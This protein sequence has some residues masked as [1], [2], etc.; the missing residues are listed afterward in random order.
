MCGLAGLVTFGSVQSEDI[1][2]VEAMTETLR[3]RGPDDSGIWSSSNVVLGHRRLS[4]IDLDGGHQP[5]Q[6]RSGN[7]I[8]LYED[9]GVDC[10]HRL[11]GMF[12]F[13]LW[14]GNQ[15]KL[16]LG[17]DRAGIKPLYYRRHADGVTF[18][19]EIKALLQDPRYS[20]RLNAD[21]L[22]EFVQFRNITGTE[23][24][25]EGIEEIPPGHVAVIDPRDG[26]FR[27]SRWWK[28]NQAEGERASRDDLTEM[29]TSAVRYHMIADVEV[30]TY[31]S[32]GVDSSLVSYFASHELDRQLHTF[33]VGFE[34]AQFDE[35]RYSNI[36]ARTIGSNHHKI[37]VDSA[38]YADDLER[39]IWHLDEPLHHAHT[40]QLMALSK[41]A[42]KYV[43]VVLTG[44][45]ADEIFA[46]YP[47]Y[48]IPFLAPWVSWIPSGVRR[49]LRGAADDAGLRRVTKL[50]DAAS[51]L[52]SS[53]VN[54]AR[55]VDEWTLRELG[56]TGS[57][58]LD[59][60]YGIYRDLAGPSVLETVLAYDRATYMQS[61]LQRLDRTTMAHSLEA[62]VPYL[63]YR[64][65]E[66]SQRLH[67]S[68]KLAVGR[69]NKILLK[70][71]ARSV[72][73]HEIIDRRKMG[74]DVP[75]HEWLR[76]RKGLGARLDLLTDE[77][78]AGRGLYD[79]RYVHRLVDEH[80]TG[81]ANHVEVLWPILNLELW[82][83]IMIEGA[84]GVS[85]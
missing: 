1:G 61:L 70:D 6:S 77:T 2:L 25:F 17:R 67:P 22:W 35:S 66:W 79:V 65:V 16:L 45:G 37:S 74:F 30:G 76:D 85:R 31:N 59:T 3:H 46:G 8:H 50:I 49:A 51:D 75:L 43:K 78:F 27:L 28:D 62:R 18:A 60:R 19:S 12:A 4:I 11:N 13:A 48:Q 21:A 10:L 34:E 42:R 23:T 63:D 39:A 68:E 44:E 24:M 47:R 56:G 64:L 55:F 20:R 29:L 26:S 71:L 36:V 33:S 15:N 52:P 14:D 82:Q 83:R 57:V 69:G 72:F 73:P 40:V 81:R 53:T 38:R 54:Q 84:V 58:G 5:M 80:I 9:E 32:G 41:E 7:R